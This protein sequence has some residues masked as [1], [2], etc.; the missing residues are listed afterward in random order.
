M[1]WIQ[2]TKNLQVKA[3]TKLIKLNLFSIEQVTFTL[4]RY[5]YKYTV[6]LGYNELGYNEYSVITN[7]YFGKIGRFTTQ[8]NPVITNKYGR[9]RAVRYNRV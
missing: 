8:M 3:H 9:S 1:G 2:Y 6:K 7:K 5:G 4:T